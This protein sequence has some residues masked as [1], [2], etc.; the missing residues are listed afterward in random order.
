MVRIELSTLRAGLN[1]LTL[2]PSAESLDLDPD[3]FDDIRVVVTLDVAADRILARYTTLADAHLLCD[4]TAE[5]FVHQVEGSHLVLFSKTGESGGEGE[6]QDAKI[7][8]TTDRYLDL[9]DEVRD[10]LVLSMPVR[11]I[12]PGAEE[13][14]IPTRFGEED[15]DGIDPRWDE[16]RK[17]QN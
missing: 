10:T 16:L 6:P 2:T 13:V 11:R 17:L 9:T 4:R 14:D 8:A 1:E 12:A 7:F 5:P 15:D 3:V